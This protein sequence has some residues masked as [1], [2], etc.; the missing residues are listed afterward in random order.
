MY[1][2]SAYLTI[3]IA[4]KLILFLACLCSYHAFSQQFAIAPDFYDSTGVSSYD[5]HVTGQ[6]SFTD[7]MVVTVELHA[8][9]SSHAVLFSGTYSFADP[10]ASTLPGFTYDPLTTVFYAALGSYPSKDM[11]MWV[12]STVDGVMRE[13]LLIVY[14]D[15]IIQEYENQ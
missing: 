11:E 2:W 6:A 8:S 7:S 15:L 4:M 12:R 10:Q 14:F 3:W 9:D 1:F 5:F 13:E